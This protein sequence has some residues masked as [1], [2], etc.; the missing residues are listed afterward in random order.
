[1]QLGK[2]LACSYYIAITF[3]TYN[4]SCT[5]AQYIYAVAMNIIVAVQ[6]QQHQSGYIAAALIVMRLYS[7][8]AICLL[9][10]STQLMQ[11]QHVLTSVN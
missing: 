5:L 7:V 1:M 8:V 2:T 3:C 10:R 9:S 6:W 11:N 4:S